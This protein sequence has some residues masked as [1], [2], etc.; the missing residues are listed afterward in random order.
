MQVAE[1]AGSPELHLADAKLRQTVLGAVAAHDDAE[2][3]LVRPGRPVRDVVERDLVTAFGGQSRGLGRMRHDGRA[4][5]VGGGKALKA[6][7]CAVRVVGD[8][9][10]AATPVLDL[11][12]RIDDQHVGAVA[13]PRSP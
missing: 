7:D 3:R 6:A 4:Y 5:V 1:A 9:L 12:P 2:L 13:G 10:V 11:V 8:A